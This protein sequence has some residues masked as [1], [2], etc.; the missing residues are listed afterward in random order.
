MHRI[1]KITIPPDIKL[2]KTRKWKPNRYQNAIWKIRSKLPDEE[3][4]GHKQID[5]MHSISKRKMYRGKSQ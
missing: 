3:K 4:Q 5:N 2:I 1:I